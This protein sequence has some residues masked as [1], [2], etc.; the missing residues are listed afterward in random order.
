M[1]KTLYIIKG[2]GLSLDGQVVIV[3][4]TVGDYSLVAPPISTTDI[5]NTM[6]KTACLQ[7]LENRQKV[8]Y[9]ITIQKTVIDPK[10]Y[11][12]IS[13]MDIDNCLR[14]VDLETITEYLETNL[15]PILRME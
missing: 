15:T 4:E 2:T 10:G 5:R 6:V 13:H 8:S 3:V 14:D 11:T 7:P 1:A 12:Q 9:H